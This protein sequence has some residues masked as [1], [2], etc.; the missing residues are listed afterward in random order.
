MRCPKNRQVEALPV[1]LRHP[2]DELA[3]D[4]PQTSHLAQ[5]QPF[6]DA[7]RNARLSGL[8]ACVFQSIETVG[9]LPTA[10]QSASAIGAPIFGL[11]GR[12]GIITAESSTPK[13]FDH[14]AGHFVQGIANIIGVVGSTACLA[15]HSTSARGAPGRPRRL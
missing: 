13:K 11:G 4:T 1:F 9:D 3:R 2:S 7:L 8:V 12:C 14:S 15:D 10:F 6:G 5:A